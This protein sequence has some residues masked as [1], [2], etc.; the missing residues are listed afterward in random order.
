LIDASIEEDLK[1]KE[2]IQRKQSERKVHQIMGKCCTKVWKKASWIRKSK[3]LGAKMGTKKKGLRASRVR[4]HS[5][6]EEWG[7]IN[8][9]PPKRQ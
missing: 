3:R 9:K 2:E 5:Q 7:R 4:R 6:H 8:T 1:R